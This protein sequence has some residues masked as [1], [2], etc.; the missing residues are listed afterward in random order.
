MDLETKRVTM[1]GTAHSGRRGRDKDM[2]ASLWR[3]QVGFHTAAKSSYRC[4]EAIKHSGCGWF[5]LLANGA[6]LASG[7]MVDV[8]L[9]LYG[10]VPYS[11][12]P[13]AFDAGP[14]RDGETDND[15]LSRVE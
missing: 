1:S 5:S 6:F 8:Y 12:L 15:R 9:V 13:S 11:L 4:F 14:K 2:T 3:D 10:E 7:T